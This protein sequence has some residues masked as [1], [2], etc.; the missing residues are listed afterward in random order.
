MRL[1]GG[2]SEKELQKRLEQVRLGRRRAGPAFCHALTPIPRHTPPQVEAENERLR[3]AQQ[4][5]I[6]CVSTLA[7]ALQSQ[8]GDLVE[9]RDELIARPAS[10]ELRTPAKQGASGAGPSSPAPGEGPH[11][12]R[13]A[14]AALT[15]RRTALY[16]SF[17][18]STVR[19][20]QQQVEESRDA[21]A[22][23]TAVSRS[24]SSEPAAG[25]AAPGPRT[26]ASSG[27]VSSRAG[28]ESPAAAPSGRVPLS[29]RGSHIALEMTMGNRSNVEHAPQPPPTP[30]PP[31]EAPPDTPPAA[32]PPP[33]TPRQ[34]SDSVKVA[35]LRG[36]SS[37][38]SNGADEGGSKW[39][40]RG[41]SGMNG[42]ANAL[43]PRGTAQVRSA[44]QAPSGRRRAT[45]SSPAEGAGAAA[46]V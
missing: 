15:Q 3:Q 28:P 17:L 11:A 37:H 46:G 18:Q 26:R 41:L 5:A 29:S 44:R 1:M 2:R 27:S 32:A 35:P 42:F 7:G 38:S 39:F 30:P 45:A 4:Q 9:V 33:T 24:A 21:L 8:L 19:I 6:A 36:A 14:A 20:L 12:N 23:A 10:P 22:A 31:V 34:S 25:A 43:T 16:L 13:A 40:R